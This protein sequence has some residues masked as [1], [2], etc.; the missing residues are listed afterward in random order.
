MDPSHPGA[1][2]GAGGGK[3][4]GIGPRGSR[5]GGKLH[6]STSAGARGGGGPPSGSPIPNRMP[7]ADTDIV[8]GGP[9]NPGSFILRQGVDTRPVAGVT[10]PG[11]SGSLASDLTI[12]S[13]FRQMFKQ[14]VSRGDTLSG[15]FIGDIHAAGFEVVH[16]PTFNNPLHVQI[17]AAVNNFDSVGREWLS[18]AFDRLARVRK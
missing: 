4:P 13:E 5:G 9:A 3:R 2:G 7:L 15:T 6:A 14:P 11:K 12:E 8:V 16:A 10:S 18:L 17:I 1:F